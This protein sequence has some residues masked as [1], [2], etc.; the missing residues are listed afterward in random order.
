MPSWDKAM[1][2]PAQQ[3]LL[4]SAQLS[5]DKFNISPYIPPDPDLFDCQTCCGWTQELDH[6][7]NGKVDM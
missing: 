7:L 1:P 4:K 3:R 5:S 6:V 2:P